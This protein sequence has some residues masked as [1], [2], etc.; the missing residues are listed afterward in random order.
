MSAKFDV[1][2]TL[3][4]GREI[5]HS[6]TSVKGVSADTPIEEVAKQFMAWL[7]LDNP[8]TLCLG[9]TIIAMNEIETVRLVDMRS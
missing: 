8:K 5:R 6:I 3:R 9:V 2:V 4:S 7:D 1:V